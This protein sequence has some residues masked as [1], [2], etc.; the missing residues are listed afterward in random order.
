MPGRFPIELA[1]EAA[2]ARLDAKGAIAA[3]E[4]GTGLEL[5]ASAVIPDLA[6]LSPLLGRKLPALRN[7]LLG[8][9]A[10]DGPD[11]FRQAVALHDLRI[12]ARPRPSSAATSCCTTQGGRRSGRR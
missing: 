10:V 7:V 8:L 1:I 6:A 9:H 3:P 12:Q 11:G 2:G 4:R 5:E